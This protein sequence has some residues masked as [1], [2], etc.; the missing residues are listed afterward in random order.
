MESPVRNAIFNFSGNDYK[1][2]RLGVPSGE[3][4]ILLNSDNKRFG[5]RGLVRKGS[6]KSTSK[7]AY[8]RENS[9]LLNVPRFSAI[10][11]IKKDVN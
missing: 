5:G 4:K 1:S 10:Y 2:F 6:Y 8:G 7:N 11:L 9:I 3:Y